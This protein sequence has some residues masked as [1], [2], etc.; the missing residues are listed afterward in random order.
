[1]THSPPSNCCIIFSFLSKADFS[2]SFF[3]Y[4][5]PKVHRLVAWLIARASPSLG[6]PLRRALASDSDDYHAAATTTTAVG[7]VT[8]GTGTSAGWGRWAASL[9]A[10]LHAV[11]PL[12]LKEGDRVSYFKDGVDSVGFYLFAAVCYAFLSLVDEKN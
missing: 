1:M 6:A 3:F 2:F 4:C 7:S 8:T 9:V 5:L 11:H 10:V 12:V